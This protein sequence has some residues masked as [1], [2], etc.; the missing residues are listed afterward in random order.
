MDDGMNTAPEPISLGVRCETKFQMCRA[1]YLQAYP[2]AGVQRLREALAARRG[3]SAFVR[4]IFDWQITPPETVAEYLERDFQGVFEREDLFVADNGEVAH[5]SLGTRHPHEFHGVDG[6]F[7]EALLDAQYPA[8][9]ARF[10][11]LAARFRRHLLSPGPFLYLQNARP[12]REVAARIV[13]A[14]GARSERHQFQLLFAE[15]PGGGPGL[16]GIDPR[17]LQAELAPV[18]TKP[19][20]QMWEGD[21]DVW[22][23][24]FARYPIALPGGVTFTRGLNPAVGSSLAEGQPLDLEWKALPGFTPLGR[25]PC[26]VVLPSLAW[27][28][29]AMSNAL[30]PSVRS[31]LTLRLETVEGRAGVSLIHPDGTLASPEHCVAEDEGPA[32]LQ[33]RIEPTAG[34]V[35][36][37]LRNYGLDGVAG[38]VRIGP[39]AWGPD[40]PAG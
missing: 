30:Q 36:V 28:Y 16:E 9:R 7:D 21:D 25:A 33:L 34:P 23:T 22:D 17:I 8:A 35:H 20:E 15:P 24:V 5:R 27:D 29:G 6:R 40:F 19:P 4:H 11:R 3:S 12:Q 1:L 31:S 39:A 32:D 37:L 38:R 14:L 18:I 26:Q 2:D 13:K 10:E